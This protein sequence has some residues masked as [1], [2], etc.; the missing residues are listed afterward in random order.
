MTK[1]S[2]VHP[3]LTQITITLY[4]VR[5]GPFKQSRGCSKLLFE[6][7]IKATEVQGPPDALYCLRMHPSTKK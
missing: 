6:P 3:I 4:F 1:D 2:F 5:G 7:C